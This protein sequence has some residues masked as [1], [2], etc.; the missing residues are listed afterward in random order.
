[1]YK[2]A[3]PG[4]QL[5]LAELPRNAGTVILHTRYYTQ[6]HPSDNRNNH[7]VIS[8]KGDIAL[9]HNGVISNDDDFRTRW[10]D[11]PQVDSAVIPAII[12]TDGI[13]GTSALAGYAAIAW[14]DASDPTA[15]DVLNIARLDSSPVVYTWLY[16]G[17]FVWASTMAILLRA[18][19]TLDLEH[20]HV[21]SMVD[22]QMLG[23]R[24]GIPVDSFEGLKMQEDWWAQYRFG[25]ATA[26]GHGAAKTSAKANSAR[27]RGIG[28]SF[29]IREG[30]EGVWD[31]TPAD[32]KDWDDM[33]WDDD[34]DIR[35]GSRM[36]TFDANTAMALGPE[37]NSPT[38]GGVWVRDESGE[39]VKQFTESL[40]LTDDN[41]GFY[42]V[43]FDGTM[44]HFESMDAMENYL[45]WLGNMVMPD[46]APFPDAAITTR[47]T[48][49]ILDLGDV[50]VRGGMNSWLEDLGRIDYYESPA[51]YNLDYIRDGASDLIILKG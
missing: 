17:S 41:K 25:N 10:P 49:H 27:P 39:L 20:G 50:T 19:G 28:S 45:S 16:D 32:A 23:I 13:F 51:T 18:L 4:S 30:D 11:L 5:P 29:G 26:G 38:G 1:V 14:L 34:N 6:G 8:P 9:V 43:H 44:E 3:V 24:H 12:E 36:V 35:T 31:D 37:S 21:F 48:N 22:G 42:I 7:P 15:A 47:W 46:N 2:A 40:S 33:S